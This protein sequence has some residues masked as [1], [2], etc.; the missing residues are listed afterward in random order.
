MSAHSL[1][2]E[3]GR[4][5]ATNLEQGICKFCTSPHVEN[6]YQYFSLSN[7]YSTSPKISTTI[8][9]EFC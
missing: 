6:V 8:W 7:S 1:E 5:N 9:L 4:Y 3:N 2:I